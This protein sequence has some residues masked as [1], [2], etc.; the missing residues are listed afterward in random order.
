MDHTTCHY[1]V[2]PNTCAASNF[3]FTFAVVAI[4]IVFIISIL[5]VLYAFRKGLI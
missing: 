1:E 2:S 5:W 4:P 3:D